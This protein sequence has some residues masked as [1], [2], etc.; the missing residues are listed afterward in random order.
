LGELSRQTVI[1]APIETV[2][3]YVSDPHNAPHYISSITRITSGPQG[4]PEEGQRWHA[5]AHF[6]GRPARL[7]LRLAEIRPPRSVRFAMEGD[8][9]ATLSLRLA[10]SDPPGYTKVLLSLEVP[11]VPGLL[12]GG[13]MGGLLS[14]DLARLKRQ[15]EG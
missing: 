11:S 2:F 9:P 7:M 15:L 14:A 12:L 1:A 13:L 4:S 6:L 10:G 8:T 3:G 5:E